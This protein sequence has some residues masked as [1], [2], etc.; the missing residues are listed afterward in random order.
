TA[1]QSYMQYDKRRREALLTP[2]A[3]KRKHYTSR[4][5]AQSQSTS[6]SHTDED[7]EMLTQPP[8]MN[9]PYDGEPQ[10]H[11]SE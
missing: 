5:S 9:S 11:V 10:F 1:T 7:Q 4:Q 6:S 3:T 8:T 2:N